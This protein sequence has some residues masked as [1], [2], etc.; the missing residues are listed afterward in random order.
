MC[1][2][3]LERGK[4][5]AENL[6]KLLFNIDLRIVHAKGEI[7]LAE[8]D[9]KINSKIGTNA[10]RQKALRSKA[11]AKAYEAYVGT[12]EKVKNN[13]QF[14]IDKVLTGYTPKHK[15]IWVM[16]FLEQKPIEEICEELHYS[17][18]N[19]NVIIKK[20]KLDL[21]HHYHEKN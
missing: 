12:L 19:I 2:A 20:L 13:I 14:N 9:F 17:K 21:D 5:I 6:R 10:S 15:K 4:L 7:E 16:Y 3:K 8:Q 11:V 18:S 1:E